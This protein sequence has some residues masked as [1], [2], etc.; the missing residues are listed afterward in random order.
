MLIILIF[1]Y[2]TRLFV[3]SYCNFP[4]HDVLGCT[5]GI[6]KKFS[7]IRGPLTWFE[8]IWNYDMENIDY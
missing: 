2:K 6:F 7:M 1:I 5:L 4:N 8:S 3:L